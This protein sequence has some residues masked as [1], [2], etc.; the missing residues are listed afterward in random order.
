VFSGSYGIG[1][2]ERQHYLQYL[3]DNKVNLVCGGSEGRD[4]F[5]TEEY[6]D[7]YKRAKIALSFSKA[8]GMSV[9]NARVFEVMNC[10]ACLFEQK[11]EELAKLYTP[12]VDYVEWITDVDLLEKIR[13]YLAHEKERSLIANNGYKK[14]V[15]LY[16]A[17]TFWTQ[18]L[19]F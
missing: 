15:E 3:I 11:S 5:T 16:S 1:R 2:E 18:C 12:G 8:H 17:K 9:V 7:R 14:T 19:N 4:H 13:Y 6:A 10:G